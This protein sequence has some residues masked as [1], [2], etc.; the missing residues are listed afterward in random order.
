MVASEARIEVR[1]KTSALALWSDGE[2]C[3]GVLTDGGP[4]AAAGD[5]PRDRRRRGAVA[6]DDQP[7]RRDRRRAG[8]RA[9]RRAPTSPTSSSASSTRPRS[10]CP[11]RPFDGVADHRGD[12]RRGRQ[13][14]RRRGRALHRRA[15]PARR[16]HRGD[17]RPHDARRA[18]PT[19]ASTCARST[20]PASPTSSPRSPRPASTRAREPVPVSPAAHYM[21]GGV[22]VDLDGRSSLPGL[23]AVGECSCTGLHGANR[24]ASNSLSECF[25]FGGR[26]GARRR[27]A[28]PPRRRGRRCP[29]GASS[30]RPRRPATPSGAAPA[31]CATPTTWPR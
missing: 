5:G 8:P 17:P 15:R 23:Y 4:I 11:D 28:R 27:S 30:R 14:A 12:P 10:P 20:R 7:A 6:P 3:H 31:P 22:D 1:E 16:G 25:V 13:A 9:R 29:S 24:L 18:A 26:A 19:S 2:R 21:M